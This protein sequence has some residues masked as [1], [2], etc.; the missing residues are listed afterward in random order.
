MYHGAGCASGG[1]VRPQRLPVSVTIG[2]RTAEV[3]EAQSAPGVPGTIQIDVRVP[4][5]APAG[6]T[7]PVV[8][9]VGDTSSQ[10]GT[11][12]VIAE[13]MNK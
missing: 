7:V 12:V 8:V 6:K 10:P 4:I 3:A 11:T 5:D 13:E 9:M 1:G 2:D